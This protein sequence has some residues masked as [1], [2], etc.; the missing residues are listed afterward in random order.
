MVVDPIALM[1]EMTDI[2]KLGVK[3][4][5][6]LQISTRAHLVLPYHKELDALNEQT[7]K[8]GEKIGTTKRGIGPAYAD[9]AARVGIRACDLLDEKLFIAKFAK[10]LSFYNRIFSSCNVPVLDEKTE[11]EKL[12]AAAN[13]IKSCITDTVLTVNKAARAGKNILFEGAQGMWL[14]VDYGTYPFVTSSNTSSGGACTGSGLS[15][16][17]IQNVI[18]VMKAYA[19]RVGEGP[20]P[21]ELCD[22][23][24]E[25]IRELGKEYG[26]STGR[27]RRCGWFDAV[28]AKYSCMVNGVDQLAITKLD[29]LDDFDEIKI[30]TRYEIDGIT[31]EDMPSSTEK[32]CL[33][34]P[35]Y[36]TMPGWKQKTSDAKKWSD[37]PEKAQ[38]Y[39]LRI[40]QLVDAK[41]AIISVG[42]RRDQTFQIGNIK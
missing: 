26:A 30:C 23:V 14:D 40:S 21:T 28:S 11:L 6:R 18:G 27:P 5:G 35:L 34:K 15:P 10:Q 38:K 32:I 20:F 16:K 7:R 25:K 22:S 17:Y 3:I 29:I 19:T 8:S 4:K 24:G 41:P 36:E 37:L 1:N 39:L 12:I 2:E 42:P 9:K 31:I 13:Y 33:A